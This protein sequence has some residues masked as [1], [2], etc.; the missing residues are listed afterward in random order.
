M[1]GSIS[2]SQMGCRAL[3]LAALGVASLIGS[4]QAAVVFTDDFSSS[5]IA[6][7]AYP[8]PTSTST[9]Y[10]IASSKNQS[11]APTIATGHLKFGMALTSGGIEE[12]QALF[13]NSPVTLTNTGDFVE[14]VLTFTNN[15]IL[16]AATTSG[17]LS[18][19]MYIS[20]GSAPKTNLQA[21]GLSS[22]LTADATGGTAGWT[23][24]V[25]QMF[26]SGGSAARLVTRP[27]Q[28][29]TENTN[30]ELVTNGASSSQSYHSP[31]GTSLGS[32]GTS[33]NLTNGAQYTAD[34]KITLTAAGTYS[35]TNVLSQGATVLSTQSKDATAANFFNGGFD[36]IAFGWR[37]TGNVNATQMDVNSLVVQTG[38]VGTV[39]EP[40]SLGLAGLAVA[41]LLRRRGRA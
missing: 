14:F 20:G 18:M 12:A 5:T 4:A 40:A 28:T 17:Q 11:P 3:M 24:Y 19:G 41:G 6:T 30:Q 32:S 9:G 1:L 35:I 15:N 39:P 10:A 29:G 16:T 31:G 37:E 21:S 33:Q 22:T 34:F 38:N 2:G 7:G 25:S 27:A 23:G 36:G 26:A 8:T 13:T